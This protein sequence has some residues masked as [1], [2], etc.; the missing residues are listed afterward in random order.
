L[1]AQFSGLWACTVFAVCLSGNAS[2]EGT[3]AVN[4]FGM[5]GLVDMPMA[6][7]FTDAQIVT[8]TAFLDGQQKIS[9]SFQ[10]TPRLTAAFRYSIIDNFR[11]GD[12]A[13]FDRS[14]DLHYRLLDEGRLR[15][16]LAVGL[17]DFIGTGVFSSEYVVASKHLGPDVSVTA[18]IGWGTLGRVNAFDNPLSSLHSGFDSRPRFAG[19][20]GETNSEQW[21]RGPAA[22]FAGAH[23]HVSDRIGISLEYA[24]DDYADQEASGIIASKSPFNFGLRY[25]ARPGVVIGA[26][27]LQGSTLGVSAHIALNPR[28]PPSGG[29]MRPAPIPIA[30]RDGTAQSWAGNVIQD[31]IPEASRTQVLSAALAQEGLVL[32]HIEVGASSVRIRLL[33]TRH[34]SAPQAIG[35]AARLLSLVMPTHIEQFEIEPSEN[36]VSLSRITLQRRDLERLE[37]AHNAVESSLAA[38][39]ISAA[40]TGADPITVPVNPF[41]WSLSPFVGLA[42]FDPSGPARAD[43]GLELGA[44]YAI[45]PNLSISSLVRGKL[46]GNR[47]SSSRVSTS[48]LPHVRSDQPLYDKDADIWLERLTLDH[49]GR[50]GSDVYTRVSAGYFEEMFAGVSGEVL[51]KP[52][53][54]RFALGAELNYVHQRDTD[55]LFGFDDYDYDVLT[56]HVSGYYA[57]RNGFDAQVDVGRY[58]AGDWGVTVGLDRRFGNGWSVGAFATLTDVSFEDFGEGSFDKGIRMTVPLSW[59]LGK[60]SRTMPG[61]TLRPIQRDGGARLTVSNRLYETVRPYH[62]PEL[63]DQWGRFWR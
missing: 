49:F 15:P 18:G 55:K 62:A 46:L 10:V 5:P 32:E 2:A 22:F 52:V 6:G 63:A 57:F 27:Y 14:F 53:T 17:R 36:G 30:L 16:A 25:E 59:I 33:N 35:R 39:E 56:G 19:L 9:L 7:S 28:F 20:G 23:W 3:K 13:L 11:G 40:G 12:G 29:D 38:A 37:Y 58:L 26:Q 42:L 51:W 1:R 61:M 60:P 31:A 21:F 44:T 48:I 50:L 47:D 8:S 43:L 41:T 45:S 54:S 34:E 4:T 24:S